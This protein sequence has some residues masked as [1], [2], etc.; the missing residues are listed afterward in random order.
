MYNMIVKAN[1]DC[2]YIE[3]KILIFENIELYNNKERAEEVKIKKEKVHKKQLLDMKKYI[4]NDKKNNELKER[5][6]RLKKVTI[7]AK[8]KIVVYRRAY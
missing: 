4:E 2:S 7:F 5:Y 3:D 8:G 6:E 1:I